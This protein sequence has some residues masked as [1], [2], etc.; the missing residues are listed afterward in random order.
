MV[1]FSCNQK[2]VLLNANRFTLLLSNESTTLFCF[3]SIPLYY[4][5]MKAS[6]TITKL[7]AVLGVSADSSYAL[8]SPIS[9]FIKHFHPM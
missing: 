2:K 3:V 9:A 4:L 5:L 8:L 6:G 7:I 1:K